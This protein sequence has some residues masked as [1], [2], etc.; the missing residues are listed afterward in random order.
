MTTQELLEKYNF[1]NLDEVRLIVN[2]AFP[3]VFRRAWTPVYPSAAWIIRAL[4]FLQKYLV[5][6]S[7]DVMIEWAKKG[8]KSK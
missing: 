7:I 8:D 4:S 5:T 3:S 1:K 2:M 6:E